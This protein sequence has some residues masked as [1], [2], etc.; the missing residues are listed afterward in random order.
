MRRAESGSR[1]HW[2]E[3]IHF[4]EGISFLTEKGWMTPGQVRR[5][6]AKVRIS[7]RLRELAD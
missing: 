4:Q 3:L 5:E 7:P 1:I 6:I 2:F